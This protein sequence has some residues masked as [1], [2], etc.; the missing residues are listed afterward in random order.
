MTGERLLLHRCCKSLL[1]NKVLAFL[2]EGQHNR[3]FFLLV[4]F[5]SLLSF[6]LFLFFLT[7]YLNLLICQ[8]SF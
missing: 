2:I 8:F 3:V 6:M 4:V 1:L 7:F 5:Y